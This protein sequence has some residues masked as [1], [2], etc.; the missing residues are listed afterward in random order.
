M[1]WSEDIAKFDQIT[2]HNLVEWSKSDQ[3]MTLRIRV[4]GTI[5]MYNDRPQIV[6][7]DGSQIATLLDDGKWFT[8]M[9]DD[10]VDRLMDLRY[11]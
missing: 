1:V 11:R 5:E 9:S 10:E 3:P 6:A 2:L 7:R 4:S 8:M